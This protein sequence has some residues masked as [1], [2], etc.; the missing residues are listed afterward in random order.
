MIQQALSDLHLSFCPEATVS[1]KAIKWDWG[2]SFIYGILHKICS[3]LLGKGKM[4]SLALQTST[5]DPN[6]TLAGL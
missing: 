2:T 6:F 1:F 5:K 4:I 3:C